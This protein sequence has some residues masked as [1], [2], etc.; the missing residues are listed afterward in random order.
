M[1]RPALIPIDLRPSIAAR[2][3]RLGLGV[4]A[5]EHDWRIKGKLARTSGRAL[6]VRYV[7]YLCSEHKYE[8]AA[9]WFV[10]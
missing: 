6:G 7:C 9:R 5:C 2:Q 3:A 10:A 1:T 4:S 8:A